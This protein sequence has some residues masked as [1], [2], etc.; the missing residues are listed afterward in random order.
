METYPSL[1][2]AVERAAVEHP[3]SDFTFH[4]MKGRARRYPFPAVEAETRA[5]AAGLRAMGLRAGD[6]VALALPDPADFVLVFLA[7]VRLGAW[8][9]PMYP[10]LGTGDLDAWAARSR[11][12]LAAAGARLL[13]TTRALAPIAWGLLGEETRLERVV[14]AS[15]LR[16]PADGTPLPEIDPETP[17]FLQFTSGSTAD[18]KGVMVSH[19]NLAANARAII[20]ETCH[21]RPGEDR[22]LAWL[23]LYH[24]MGLI[25][26]V[27]ST[28]LHGISAT[29]LPTLRFLARPLSWFEAMAA[30]GA[31]ISFAPNFAYALSARRCR[32]ADVARLDLSRVH[33]MGCGAEPIHPDTLRAFADHFAPAGLRGDTLM[34][35]YGMAEAT[36]AMALRPRGSGMRTRR[37]ERGGVAVEDVSCGPPVPGHGMRVR[38]EDGRWLGE[39]EE[40]ELVFE[41]P[42]VTAGYWRNPEAT[43]AVFEGG[44]VRTGDLGY[45]LDGEV[46][47]TGRLKD[48]VIVRGRNIH[49]QAVEW[50]AAEVEGVRKGNVVAFA[51]P[52][53]AGEELVVVA[54]TRAEP[55]ADLG[56]RVRAAVR[57]ATGVD[58]AEVAFVPRGS[59]PKTSSGKL[60]RRLTRELFLAGRLGQTG[61]RVS[62]GRS[63]PAA[64]ARHLGRGALARLRRAARGREGDGEG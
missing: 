5:R 28:L 53:A 29:F 39:G 47:V 33:T 2:V 34:P 60:Q 58:P 21:M 25:G 20:V 57:E 26:F 8:P 41:G 22:A 23:P 54:E 19:A 45:I 64:L 11:R 13:V 51:R 43:A 32:P 17:A 44:R 59:L 10:P 31:T 6:R 50:A 55:D 14:A 56:P 48:L 35:A 16:D 37:A 36:L 46:Y 3:D 49:P 62:S 63:D 52:G 7:A 18:P 9:V 61:R 27:S 38:G 42:S 4:D 40:G 15:A 12:I 1:A 30:E 24:D